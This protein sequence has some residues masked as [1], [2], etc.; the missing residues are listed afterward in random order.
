MKEEINW[1]GKEEF[2]LKKRYILEI[3][4]KIYIVSVG[5]KRRNKKLL[6]LKRIV[7]I[8]HNMANNKVIMRNILWWLENVMSRRI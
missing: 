2:L 1:S 5:E 3:M 7:N 6:F 8:L 4:K